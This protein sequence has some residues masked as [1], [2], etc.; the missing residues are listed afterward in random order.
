MS[1]RYKIL[2]VVGTLA[3]M[4]IAAR[5]ALPA[6][7]KS[8]VN[9]RIA[10]MGEYSG[11]AADIDIALIRGAYQIQ[12]LVIEKR[13]ADTDAPF[14]NVDEVDISLQWSALLS[15]ALVGEIVARRPIVYL[16][17]ATT[18]EDT[19]L[20]RGINWTAEIR[21]LFPFKFNS[22]EAL[23][24]IVTFRAPGIDEDEI[25]TLS[26]TH[27]KLEN[28]TNV[29]NRT[30]EAFAA[31]DLKGRI[32]S[33]APFTVTGK[34]NPNATQPTFDIN[35]EL[36]RTMLVD[37]NPWLQRFLRIDAEQ[38]TFSLYWARR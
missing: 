35:V 18:N 38:G 34:I 1:T 24:G 29:Q 31:L 32:M 13:A 19:Q 37:V 8:Y 30:Q 22:V 4:L 16:V 11:H 10:E 12:Q 26:D 15:G 3:F 14:L 28:L 5:L 17:Q 2:A 9:S 33:D 27:L 36:Q 20:G 23:D 6:A 7:V 21:E 25:L